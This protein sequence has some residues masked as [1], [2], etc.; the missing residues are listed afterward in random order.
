MSDPVGNINN[1]FQED[2]LTQF[3]ARVRFDAKIF[4]HQHYCGNWAIDTSREG[5]VPFHLIGKGN[6]WVHVEGSEPQLLQAGDLVLFPRAHPHAVS[7]DA[8]PPDKSLINA[9]PQYEMEKVFTS[10][11]CGFYVFESDAAQALLDDLPDVVL[12]IDARKNTATSGLGH[13]I[14][15]ALFELENN[16]PGRTSAVCDLTRLLFLHLLRQRLTESTSTGYL[17]AL[18]DT[19]ISKALLLIHS[20]YGEDWTLNR[21]ASETGMSRT[22]FAGKFHAYVGM[23]PAKYLTAWRMQE[24]TTL[25]ETNDSEY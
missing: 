23:P 16:M 8:S 1:G 13:I 6:A 15:A 20:R 24:A 11:L 22:S 10:I 19:Q 21:L 12:L 2:A 14:D 3:L 5:Q 18:S 7:N 25:L 4:N 17:A 9:M